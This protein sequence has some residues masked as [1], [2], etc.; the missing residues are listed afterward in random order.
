MLKSKASRPKA[1]PGYHYCQLFRL[2]SKVRHG[3]QG[4]FCNRFS[5]TNA[6]KN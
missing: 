4:D 3:N 1:K 6:S 2:K 5:N